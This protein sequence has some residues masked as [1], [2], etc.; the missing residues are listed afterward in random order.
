MISIDWGQKIINIPKSE[1]TLIQS[2]PIEIRELNI[3]NFRL[4]LKELEATVEGIAHLRTHNHN[5]E[6]LL[7]GIIYARVVEII[8][9]YTVTFENGFYA[10]N[11]VGAN[12]NI[13]DTIN[14]NNVSV[15]SANAA[16][17]ISNQA[18][19]FSSFNGGVT[20]DYTKGVSGTVFPRG[21]PQ[22]PVN[23]ISDANLIANLRGFNTLYIKGDF[24]FDNGDN[25]AGYNVIGE[26]SFRTNLYFSGGS[27]TQ[28]I[29]L[30]NAKIR[31][32]FD[33]TA[34]FTDCTLSNIN[35]VNGIIKDCV[36]EGKI[37]LSGNSTSTF[38]DCNDGLTDGIPSIDFDGVGSSLA[39]R[40]YSGDLR[41]LNKTGPE[42]VEVNMSTGGHLFLDNTIIDGII[43]ITGIA[44][45]TDETTGTTIV[46]V[47][48]VIFPDQLQL[49]SFNGYIYIDPIKG[50]SGTKF[51][52]GTL[53]T[54][55]NNIIDAFTIASQRGL[56]TILFDGTL[57]LSGIDLS[58]KVIKGVNPLNSVIVLANGNTTV[59]TTF[60]NTIIVG[61]LNGHIFAEA[62]TL[63]TLSNV[64]ST[65][66][67]SVFRECIIRS[68]SGSVPALKFMTGTTLQN[69]HF[70]DCA[71]G[72][73]GS[74]ATTIDLN[75]GDTT[76]AF[77]RFGGGLLIKNYTAGQDSTFEFNQGQIILDNSNTNGSLRLGGIYK[78]IN[79]STL[80]IE[81][82]NGSIVDNITI[83]GGTFTGD[84]SA[85]AT[86]VW[87][88]LTSDHT[89][90]ATFGKLLN[91][92]IVA[93][94]QQQH[95]LNLNTEL[96]KNKPNNP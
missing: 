39:I 68:D 66:F 23:N 61:E 65:V 59:K 13:G 41:L 64:G 90:A 31:G 12:S 27:E 71:S 24:T 29:N 26:S 63:Q 49:T 93:S 67:P 20:V 60:M 83:S 21:T 53:Q 89:T 88:K 70:F 16:G 69:V 94:G 19:E 77:R 8:N 96:L 32:D 43:K 78:L 6:V 4:Q 38:I 92:L 25:V 56:D 18:I 37:T 17:L 44:E 33:G 72:V 55:S 95:S 36:L 51:P 73:P 82:R 40:N 48:N 80:F 28:N 85:I 42:G 35:F 10:V 22:L 58:N 57:V 79:D 81:E 15:R 2:S 91:D 7:G 9:G 34:N 1:L 50:I 76:I 45:I 86:A 3:N 52:I 62:C 30:F 84:T 14:F 46:D 54:P 75:G 5:T 47:S 11:L 74:A 87:D